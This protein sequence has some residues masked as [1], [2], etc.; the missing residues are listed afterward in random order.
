MN[1]VEFAAEKKKILIIGCTPPPHHGQAIMIQNLAATNF[2]ELKLYLVRMSFSSAMNDIGK[3]N[4]YKVFH[5]FEVVARSIYFRIR[6]DIKTFYYS[7]GGSTKTP[8]IRDIFILFFLRMC[9]KKSV[10]HFHS[11]GTAL[12]VDALPVPLKLLAKFVY[13]SPDVGIYLSTKNLDHEYLGIPNVAIV[14]NGL[15]DD[16]VPYVPFNRALT[17]N[18]S[19]LFVGIIKESKGVMV[20]LQAMDRLKRMGYSLS[21]KFM[22]DFDSSAFKKDVETFCEDHGLLSTVEFVGVKHDKDKWVYFANADVFC[23]PSFYQS[24]S[25][26]NVLVEAMMFEL[27]VIA[28]S[29]RGIPDIVDHEVTGILVPIQD[30]TALAE[31]VRKLIENP[32]RRNQ[33][34]KSGRAKYLQK[35]SRSVFLRNMENLFRNIAEN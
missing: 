19:I 7:P 29:W 27:P 26:G 1:G 24:E 5:M 8:I 20:L 9:F 4:L 33:M 11:A 15:E 22:G 14:P 21:G 16:A 23:F 32:E 30:S 25:F 31:A 13:R 12:L 2:D 34:G 3:F 6:Y 10:F 17:K 18:I 35:F 28:T